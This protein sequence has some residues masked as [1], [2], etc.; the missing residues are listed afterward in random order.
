MGKKKT[1]EEYKEQL[2]NRNIECLEEYK[3]ASTKILHKCLI[4]N[5]EWK[6]VPYSILNGSGCPKCSGNIRKSTEEYKEQLK[7]TNIEPL[8]EYQGAN[9]KILHKCLICGN[10]WKV[11]PN[12]LL[13]GI[14]C[15]ACSRKRKTSEEYKIELKAK[16]PNII[17]LEEYKT[18][19]SEI[20]HKCLICGNIWKIAPSDI[21]RGSCPVC[22]EKK[23]T[24]EQYK[25]EIEGRSIE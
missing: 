10:T 13:I 1:T 18:C 21:L 7:N 8:E 4:C 15:P 16:N 6:V 20:L 17:C 3:N 23:K 25:K 11:V 9:T 24:T 14:G 22:S 19:K 2:K 12:S 5:Y